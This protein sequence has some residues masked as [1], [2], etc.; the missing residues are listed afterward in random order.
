MFDA[1]Y[2]SIKAVQKILNC[3]SCVNGLFQKVDHVTLKHVHFSDLDDTICTVLAVGLTG[4]H[5][6]SNRLV[7]FITVS[8]A[9]HCSRW[10]VPIIEINHPIAFA[11]ATTQINE[12]IDYFSINIIPIGK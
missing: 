4:T 5:L 1:F 9:G 8:P 6:L 7:D 11:N 3:R 12:S 10:R 2:T